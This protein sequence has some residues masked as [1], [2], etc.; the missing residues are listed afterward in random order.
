[1]PNT[2]RMNWVFPS[3]NQTPYFDAI[4]D[5][6]GQQDAAAY[7]SREDRHV[8]LRGGGTVAFVT[9]GGTL[10]WT[11]D[12]EMLAAITGF[13]WRVDGPS[14]IQLL[15][16]EIAWVDLVRGPSS[17]VA[18]VLQKGNQIPSSNTAHILCVRVGSRVYFFNGASVVEGSP[19]TD[20]GAGGGGGGSSLEILDE[21]ASQTANA[22][23][24]DFVGA[25]VVAS[26]VG[27]DVTVTIPGGGGASN[28]QDAYDGG[29]VIALSDANGPVEINDTATTVATDGLSVRKTT[30]D[31]VAAF[32]RN[33]QAGP[34]NTALFTSGKSLFAAP[35]AAQ[36]GDV[37]HTFAPGRTE[38]QGARSVTQPWVVDDS[39][40][41]IGGNFNFLMV[42]GDPDT[43]VTSGDPGSLAVNPATGS[44][45]KKTANPSTWEELGGGGY[46]VVHFTANGPLATVALGVFTDGLKEVGQVATV[47]AV[48][49]SQEVDGS[50]GATTVEL[51]KANPAGAETQITQSSTLSLAFGGGA[52]ARTV[53]TL[54]IG[55]NGDLAAT[56][57][58]G[59]KFTGVQTAGAEVTVSVLVTGAVIAAAPGLPEDDEVTQA[60]NG[61]VLGT[62]F[63]L[64]GS[65]YLPAGTILAADS[66]VMLGTDQVAD[67]ADLEIR[68][69]TGGAVIDTLQAT[70][71]LQDVQPG[72]DIV[73]PADDWYDLYLKADVITTNAVL[74]GLKFVYSVGQGTRIRQAH[75][76][77][78][79]GTTPKLV[80][81][82]YLPGGSLG[83]EARVML[84]TVAGGTASLELRRF[85]GGTLIYTWTATGA[86]QDVPAIGGIM[87][88]ANDW[89]D[90]YLYGDAGPTVAVLKGLDWTVLT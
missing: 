20:V 61:T 38:T 69:F 62:T 56:D 13:K 85:T 84:G 32:F 41:A 59:I 53:S 51:Y 54:F 74:R 27:S 82:V 12:F 87:I 68:R 34:N 50:A 57:R 55:S 35:S 78:Q 3:E 79:T 11:D 2:P 22:V 71:V 31:G 6:Y 49:L 40:A 26:A 72:L 65:V 48:Y 28:L 36:V 76:E 9:A 42:D 23:S 14:N 83:A 29:E 25:G 37:G 21:G 81:S 63:G 8:I 70:G 88:P 43:H 33:E 75:D 64:V 39:L 1:M 4:E 5:F 19:L 44:I 86:L 73:V 10:S 67:T 60:I 24:I 18:L 16:G 80:G 7:A 77:N 90:L 89:Y 52:N 66:R 47:S 58:L 15:D 17:N 46:E 30:T 45:Y